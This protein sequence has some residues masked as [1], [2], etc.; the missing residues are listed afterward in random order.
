MAPQMPMA[1]RGVIGINCWRTISRT[2]WTF[3]TKTYIIG[4]RLT[5]LDL[6]SDTIKVI[7]AVGEYQ[8]WNDDIGDSEFATI[9]LK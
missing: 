3:E 7:G 6:E 8:T 2:S 5:D 9:H 1:F 4:V